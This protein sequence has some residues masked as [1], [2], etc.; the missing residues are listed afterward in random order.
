MH[1]YTWVGDSGHGSDSPICR[2]VGTGGRSRSSKRS[3]VSSPQLGTLS[4]I[5]VS[6][7]VAVRA[8]IFGMFGSVRVIVFVCS[9]SV[10]V[11]VMCHVC[12]SSARVS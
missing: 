3:L 2:Y 8:S 4:P 10:F 6:A 7:G 1:I 5:P 9:V 11:R 12:V